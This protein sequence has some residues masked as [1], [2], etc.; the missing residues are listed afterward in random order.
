VYALLTRAGD[1]GVTVR[2]YEDLIVVSSAGRLARRF[3]PELGVFTAKQQRRLIVELVDRG[4][5]IELEEVCRRSC[6]PIISASD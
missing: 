6:G 5:R 2:R 4:V 3:R 1:Y